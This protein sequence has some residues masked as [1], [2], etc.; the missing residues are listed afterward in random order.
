MTKQI[1]FPNTVPGLSTREQ[2]LIYHSRFLRPLSDYTP[3][4]TSLNILHHNA[5][6]LPSKIDSYCTLPITSYDVISISETWLKPSLPDS[7]ANLPGF[8]IFRE[9]R[10]DKTGGGVALYVKQKYSANKLPLLSDSITVADTVWIKI[11]FPRRR[12]IIIGSIYFPPGNNTLNFIEQLN[13]TLEN[14]CFTSCDV[15]LTGDFNINF[16]LDSAHKTRLQHLASSFNLTQ[17]IK[18]FTY[19]APSSGRESLLDLFFISKSLLPS[20]PTVLLTD[21]S[22]HYAIAC[23]I[24]IN[25]P[26]KPKQ[27]VQFR[28]F[29]AGMTSLQTDAHYNAQLVTNISNSNHPDEQAELLED[30]VTELVEKHFPLRSMRIRPESPKWLTAD[31]KKLIAQKNRLFRKATSAPKDFCT[32]AWLTYKTFRNTIQTKIKCAKKDFYSSQF[33]KNTKTFF[34][35][36]NKL[37]NNKP[38]HTNSDNDLVLRDSTGLLHSCAKKTAALLNSFYTRGLTP[39]DPSPFSTENLEDSS[40]PRNCL[41]KFAL[42]PE[43]DVAK[44]LNKLNKNKRGGPEQIPA[45][46]YKTLSY[47]IIPA[48]TIIINTCIK[49]SYFPARYK[50]ALVTPKFK[51]GDVHDPSNYRPI[52]SLPILSKVIESV[53]NVQLTNHLHHSN[54][55]SK[56]Q[57]G[58]R[59]GVSTEQTLHVLLDEIYKRIDN[60]SPQ[61]ICLLS[62]DIS[63][64]FD[65]VNHTTLLSKLSSSFHLSA[66]ATK[67]ISSY[68]SDRTQA[69]KVKDATSSVANLHQ[70]VPQ[71]SVLGPL[72][73]NL[74]I[75]DL[76]QQQP[77]TYAYADDTVIIQSAH[78]LD[79][80]IQA[81][82]TRLENVRMWLK[83]NSFTLNTSKTTCIMWTNKLKTFPSHIE[84]L[85]HPIPISP[86]VKLLGVTIDSKLSFSP[87]CTHSSS[88]ASSLLYAFR[89]I[90]HLLN[91]TQ[92]KLLYTSIIRPKIEYCS[93]LF[94]GTSQVNTDRLEACQNRAIR[95]ICQAPPNRHVG[96]SVSKAR[97]KLDL[98]SLSHRRSQKIVDLINM[99]KESTCSQAFSELVT[100]NVSQ[101]TN[102]ATRTKTPHI[103]PYARTNYGKRRLSFISVGRGLY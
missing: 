97:T 82:Q 10:V 14:P 26:R 52:S 15:I 59:K 37:L 68:L 98:P 87:F 31:L 6:S 47:T 77:Q 48:M 86:T 75:N 78:S 99:I 60:P 49:S 74:M 63:K 36:A 67:L 5:H 38:N 100:Q 93:T 3:S 53:I 34:A 19:I 96:F 51:K 44:A 62:L 28:N 64:A 39:G 32:E 25:P 95:I 81:T 35:E 30:W 33:S 91:T 92:A 101:K 71:G 45:A 20:D 80:C 2:S 76:L 41:F 42:I 94:I 24:I 79:S 46:V 21:L 18:G 72:L 22:D 84:L 13:T 17:V 50:T 12:Q 85:G 4:P 43:S 57:F 8:K 23:S 83:R 58:F 27:I 29:K 16:N 1:C 102:H 7:H 11:N 69:T 70:G 90:R 88:S 66:N 73:F 103:L 61:Y 65:S 56:R 55:L 89:K 54:L 9:D 40:S